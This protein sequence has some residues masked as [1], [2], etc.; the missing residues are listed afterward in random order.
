[1]KKLLF[2]LGLTLILFGCKKESNPVSSQGYFFDYNVRMKN[3]L[4]EPTIVNGYWGF[5]KEYKGD[6]MPNPDAEQAREPKIKTNRLVFYEAE[7]K[8]KIEAAA[9]DRNGTTFYDMSKINKEDLQP[10]F[11]IYPNREGFYQFDT[12]GKKYIGFI[13]I[14][15]RL[16]YMNGGI[17]EFGGLNNQL[18]N[19]DMRIDYE[20]TF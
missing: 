2:I 8:D 19:F 5:V 9:I 6:F 1:M 18:I 7:F 4:T 13:Q 3:G 20:A 17:K 14:S 11:Y 12:N 10:K 15:K 16:L